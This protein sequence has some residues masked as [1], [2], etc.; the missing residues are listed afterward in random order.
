M[1]ATSSTGRLPPLQLG[2]MPALPY[3]HVFLPQYPVNF[4]AAAQAWRRLRWPVR[5]GPAIELDVDATIARRSRV[6]MVTP[7][8]LRPRRRNRARL[9][10]LVDRQGSMAPFHDYVEEV[11]QAISQAGRLR[12]VATFYFHDVPLE[13][14]DPAL[15]EG[16]GLFDNLDSILAEIPPLI[17]GELFADKDLAIPVSA[18]LVLSE[19]AR[20]AAVLIVSDAGAARG[21]YDLRRLLDTIAF[22]KGLHEFADRGVLAQSPAV[23]RM[24]AEQRHRDRPAPADVRDGSGRHASRREC[25][26]RPALHH[27]QAGHGGCEPAAPPA[28]SRTRV[29]SR[30][31]AERRVDAF[32]RSRGPELLQLA[33]HAALPV[34]LD[35]PL[36]HLL[37]V[38][39]FLDPPDTLTFAAEAQLLLS[40]LCLE[41]DDGLYVMGPDERDVLLQK[42]VTD[43]G[44]GR[45]RDVARLLWEYCERGTPWLARPGLAEAQ[46]LTAL[47]F[48]DPKSAQAWLERAEKENAEGGATADERW[49][50]AMRKDLDGRTK[51]VEDAQANPDTAAGSLPALVELR[52]ALLGI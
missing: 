18:R 3:D 49:F 6:G 37:R 42:L 44:G 45:L 20:G 2:E 8:V 5:E 52:D 39:Y 19:H 17:D 46:Q 27:R 31:D 43:Y 48:I 23:G 36:L 22:L 38:N 51:A 13:G 25:P 50:V 9:L 15:L 29:M 47:N 40:P 30:A 21:N 16:L 26:A 34:V 1:P 24:G 41:I 7:P 10:L 32:R 33:T 11:C 35:P 12:Q 14:T 28:R 4:R